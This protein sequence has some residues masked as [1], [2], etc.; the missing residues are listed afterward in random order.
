MT[1]RECG[2]ETAFMTERERVERRQ[3]VLLRESGKETDR[4][5]E[6]EWKGA[7][8]I[9]ERESG[10]YTAC[11]TERGWKGDSLYDSVS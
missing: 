2:K 6:R 10:K 4:M 5:S 1:D 9:H 3:P 8:C 7:A 11:M